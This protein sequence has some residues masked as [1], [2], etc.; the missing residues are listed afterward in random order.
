[1][2]RVAIKTLFP[3]RPAGK[4]V[5]F[6]PGGLVPDSL[7]GIPADGGLKQEAVPIRD[8]G[9]TACPRADDVMGFETEI[10]N[11]LARNARPRLPMPDAASL[12][13]D[14]EAVALK[15]DGVVRGLVIPLEG[16][17][18]GHR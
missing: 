9:I 16:G 3:D 15:V 10:Q 14:M 12:P 6:E 18:F 4:A 8:I 13:F 17:D 7:L 11:R 1:M 5:G 2:V